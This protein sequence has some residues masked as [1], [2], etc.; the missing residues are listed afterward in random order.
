MKNN[1]KV[2]KR[3]QQVIL[4]GD[5][6]FIDGISYYEI[7]RGLL[8][9][10][11]NNQLSFFNEL[12]KRYEL[13]LLNSQ[14]IFDR[15]ASIYAELRRKGKYPHDADILIASI[16]DTGKFTL[17]S[18]NVTHFNDIQDLKIEDWLN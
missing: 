6:I 4:T 2:K 12:C 13:V 11:A 7:K 15:A 8:Y 9:R 3:A 10:D 17:V 14:S 5:D 1:D 16:A 18:N